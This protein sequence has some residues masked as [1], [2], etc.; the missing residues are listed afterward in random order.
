MAF[1]LMGISLL[2][3]LLGRLLLSLLYGLCLS[4]LIHRSRMYAHV[5]GGEMSFFIVLFVRLSVL[6]QCWSWQVLFILENLD[7]QKRF[8]ATCGI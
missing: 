4:S 8:V 1:C 3:L 6:M 5:N 7:C 2:L